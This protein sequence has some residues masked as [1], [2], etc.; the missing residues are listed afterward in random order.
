M[1]SAGQFNGTTGVQIPDS[2][3]WRERGAVADIKNQGRCGSC[4]AFSTTGSIEGQHFI[5]TGSLKRLSEQNLIDCSTSYG[6][7]GCQG[8]WTDQAFTYIKRNGGIDTEES[9]PYQAANG[10]CRYNRQNSGAM[11]TGF[12]DIP[13]GDEEKLKEALATV[14][15]ISIAIDSSHDSF[16]HYASG[17]YTEPN[18][19]PQK[20]C[21]AILAVGYGTDAN[22]NDYYIVKNSWGTTWGENGYIKI[23]RNHNNHCGI[24]TAASYP[25]I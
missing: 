2:I 22:G 13:T 19:D 21:H 6:N 5:K 4:W 9:Y 20:L 18:C 7:N 25:I 17:V 15:P 8:G 23:A 12:M 3:D 1:D 24:A 10:I 14:G 11:I 16:R